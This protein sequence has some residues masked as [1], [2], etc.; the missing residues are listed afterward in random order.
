MR[1]PNTEAFLIP[2]GRMIGKSKDEH[3]Q[4]LYAPLQDE[5][6]IL[7][8]EASQHVLESKYDLDEVTEVPTRDITKT[9]R[10]SILPNLKC[11]FSCS[12]CYSAQGRSSVEM[13][14]DTIHAA[15]DYFIDSERIEPGDISIFISGGG[16]PIL[17]W[18]LVERI[19]T[20]SHNRA[21][22]K[23]FKLNIGLITNASLINDD[24]AKFLCEYGVVVGVS[25]EVLEDLQNQQRGCFEKV[26]MGIDTLLQQGCTV[27]VNSTI[28]PYSVHRMREML[29]MM[30]KKYPNVAAYTM[31][32]VTSI[33]LFCNA[34][35][36][37]TFYNTFFEEY[38]A[39]RK[40]A[41]EYGLPLRFTFDD[42]YRGSVVRHCPGKFCITPTGAISACHL[43]SSPKEPRFADCTYG[44]VDADGIRIDTEKFAQLYGKNV[45][46]YSECKDCYAKWSCGG[47][48]LTRR[49]T[50]PDTYMKE[51]CRF[52]RRILLYQLI[53]EI[54]SSMQDEYDQNIEEF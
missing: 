35:E 27:K 41:C 38:V 6:A 32:P 24:I 2:I 14:W 16:E 12:Y 29:S 52:N 15:I 34:E 54:K 48:C 4:I 17:S 33:A 22:E 46:S 19:I 20:Y 40:I 25:F 9:R 49:S 50:Y 8:Q 36:L 43:V 21:E 10:M 26:S 42:E 13:E 51:V 44:V 3:A 47:E 53:E 1:I 5:L 31:E 28:T 23:G 7:D 30:A 18:Q 11:N 39:C 37:R 45:L